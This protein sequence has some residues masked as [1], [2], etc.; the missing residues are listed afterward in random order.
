MKY[1]LEF[2][3]ISENIPCFFFLEGDIF[4]PNCKIVLIAK[5]WVGIENRSRKLIA[6]WD[7]ISRSS[8]YMY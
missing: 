2:S 7:L 4:P 3:L 8:V 5:T 1:D 6:F